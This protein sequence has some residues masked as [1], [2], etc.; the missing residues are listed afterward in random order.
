MLTKVSELYVLLCV[1]YSGIKLV[2]VTVRRI[3]GETNMEKRMD[4]RTF[5]MQGIKY[6]DKDFCIIIFLYQL[7]LGIRL[8][9]V[10]ISVRCVVGLGADSRRDECEALAE[11]RDKGLPCRCQFF[12]SFRG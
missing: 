7:Y 2:A 5:A 11:Q 8:V 12:P 10:V 6:I 4:K 1:F 9:A 3:A